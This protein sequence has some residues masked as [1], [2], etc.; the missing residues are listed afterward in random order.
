MKQVFVAKSIDEAKAMA[1][2]EFGVEE[3]KISFNV[4]EEPKKGL[5]GKLK[6]EAKVEAEY[7][8]LRL[9]SQRIISRVFLKIWVLTLLLMLPK[10]KMVL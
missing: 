4:I 10:M 6:G 5:F 1:V 2:T 7:E 9:R 8:K 3:S